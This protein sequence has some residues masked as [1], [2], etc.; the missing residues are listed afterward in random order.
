MRRAITLVII[1]SWKA[2]MEL[3]GIDFG[4]GPVGTV[5]RILQALIGQHCSAL[6]L[7]HPSGNAKGKGVAGAGGNQNI[8]Q[9]PYAVHQLAPEPVSEGN[10]PAVRWN[11]NK[12]RG[13]SQREF[14]YTLTDGGFKV[15]E[16]EMLR[17]CRDDLLVTL[18]D[19]EGRQTATTSSAICQLLPHHSPKTVRNNLTMARQSGLICKT[20]SSWHLT[21]KGKTHLASLFPDSSVGG[22]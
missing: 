17:N 10:P 22:V 20:G 5:V 13:Y 18:G 11:A 15:I 21:R 9:N 16:G 1:D 19:I 7:H 12:L 8:N 4:I 3:A 2:V 14:V 6:Y